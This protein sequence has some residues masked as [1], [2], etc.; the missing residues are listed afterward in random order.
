MNCRDTI[1]VS[2]I[3]LIN[4]LIFV[5]EYFTYASEHISTVTGLKKM[6]VLLNS[7]DN[8]RI[9]G[10]PQS[11]VEG[12]SLFLG[13]IACSDGQMLSKGRGFRAYVMASG[14]P[15]AVTFIMKTSTSTVYSMK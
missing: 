1:I 5:K 4:P 6:R 13:L 11:S 12:I 14:T 9:I 10:I 2:T 15:L 3:E 8:G 7:D